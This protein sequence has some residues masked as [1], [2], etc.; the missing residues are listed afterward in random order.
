MALILFLFPQERLYN[1]LS[2]NDA[3]KEIRMRNSTGI[4]WQLLSF[5]RILEAVVHNC[6]TLYNITADKGNYLQKEQIMQ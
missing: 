5:V 6:M 3:F 4:K 1:D 2:E